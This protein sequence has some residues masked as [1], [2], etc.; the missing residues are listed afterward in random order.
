[1]RFASCS[2]TW[3]P[4]GSR[5]TEIEQFGRACGSLASMPRWA[6]LARSAGRSETSRASDCAVP[7]LPI[8][9]KFPTPNVPPRPQIRP[10]VR[11]EPGGEPQCVAVNAT[12]RGISETGYIVNAIVSTDIRHSFC[13]RKTLPGT[14]AKSRRSLCD[15]SA[16]DRDL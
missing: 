1:V 13:R 4:S 9:S 12:A 11:T 2:H 10:I 7:G 16:I 5:T 14:L 3:L 6:S 15:V 8:C